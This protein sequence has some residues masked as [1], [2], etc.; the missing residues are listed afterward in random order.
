LGSPIKRFIDGVVYW[1]E[2]RILI[3]WWNLRRAVRKHKRWYRRFSREQKRK[4]KEEW[5]E[6]SKKQG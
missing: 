2:E 3:R 1:R 4:R 6:W 5:L